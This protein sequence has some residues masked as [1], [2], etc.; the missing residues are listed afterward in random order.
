MDEL[1]QAVAL[2]P[3]FLEVAEPS[4]GGALPQVH[5]QVLSPGISPFSKRRALTARQLSELFSTS[6]V[7]IFGG[8]WCTLIFQNQIEEVAPALTAVEPASYFLSR[9]SQSS[10]LQRRV[11]Y[12]ASGQ[13]RAYGSIRGELVAPHVKT[14]HSMA[15]SRRAQRLQVADPVLNRL[16]SEP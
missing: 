5:Q 16:G 6:A 12:S 3:T 11:A 9:A 15:V 13:A 14:R 4:E 2:I 1:E 8:T 10:N 7:T